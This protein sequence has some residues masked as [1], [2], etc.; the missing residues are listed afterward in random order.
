IPEV[1]RLGQDEYDINL[2]SMAVVCLTKAEANL[3]QRTLM[4]TDLDISINK[5]HHRA[6]MV[7]M[8]MTDLAANNLDLRTEIRRERRIELALEGQRYYDILRWKEGHRLA[9][10]MRGIKAAWAP[11]QAHLGSLP[12]DRDGYIVVRPGERTFNP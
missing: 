11:V 5:L 8:L 6:G 12:I 2:I 10:D 7:L 1:S 3:E 9:E 4:Q